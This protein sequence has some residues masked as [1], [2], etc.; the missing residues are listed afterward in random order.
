MRPQYQEQKKFRKS[1]TEKEIDDVL[2]PSR[3]TLSQNHIYTIMKA[4]EGTLKH[5]ETTKNN[6]KRPTLTYRTHIFVTKYIRRFEQQQPD[7][8][9]VRR[10]GRFG[11]YCCCLLFSRT[12]RCCRRVSLLLIISCSYPYHNCI[13]TYVTNFVFKYIQPG[14]IITNTRSTIGGVGTI[15]SSYHS[16][17]VER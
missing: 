13:R 16:Y 12:G 17:C 10:L 3:R 14:N 6:T 1:P 9:S 5:Y 4:K 2:V 8:S 11:T 7:F 15:R